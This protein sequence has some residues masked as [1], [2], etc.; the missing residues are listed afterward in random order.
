MK[1]FFL[2]PRRN[3]FLQGCD[4][5]RAF[6]YLARVLTA[7]VAVQFA[8][9]GMSCFGSLLFAQS[10][11]QTNVTIHAPP[12]AS[13]ERRLGQPASR[14]Q[15][16]TS[17]WHLGQPPFVATSSWNVPIPTDATY[18]DVGFPPS[19]GWNYGVSWSSYAPA[20]WFSAPGDPTVDVLRPDT[21]GWPAGTVSLRIPRGITGADGT[22]GEILVI[23][24]TR[25]HNM[26]QFVRISETAATASGVRST[27]S[28]C[29]SRTEFMTCSPW[30]RR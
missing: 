15:A 9:L 23:D 16:Q 18:V 1:S 13:T 25:V 19:N 28:R 10:S 22:D 11:P 12:G 30:T 2:I 5:R 21:W 6:G 26:W 20:I 17:E 8:P 7:A 3:Q 24:G 27:P 14:P 4:S 29:R